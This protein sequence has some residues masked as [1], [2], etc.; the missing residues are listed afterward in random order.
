MAGVGQSATGILPGSWV[1]GFFRDGLS[2]QDPIIMGTIASKIAALPDKTKGFSDPSG[3]NPSKVGADIPTEAISGTATTKATYKQ[4]LDLSYIAPAYPNNQVIKTRAGHVIEYDNT[5]GKERVSLMHKT[6]AFIEID[7]SGNINVCGSTL[8]V[9]GA[10]VNVNGSSAINLT[11][12]YIFQ[13]IRTGSQVMS[14]VGPTTV[15]FPAL[16]SSNYVIVVG[17]STRTDGYLPQTVITGPSSFT[18]ELNGTG[19][20]GTYY[21]AAIHIANTAST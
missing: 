19:R 5:S 2:A 20:I 15:S 10:M 3:T 1:I 17:C 8:N 9:N 14:G 11:S 18:L 13:N 7:P 12:P 21:W 16:P 4:S 6:G